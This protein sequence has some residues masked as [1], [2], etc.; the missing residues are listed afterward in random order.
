MKRRKVFF[1]LVLTVIAIIALIGF[2]TTSCGET[3]NEDLLD[4]NYPPGEG[5][6]YYEVGDTRPGGGIIFYYD[7]NGFTMAD[8]GKKAHYLEAAPTDFPDTYE[9]RLPTGS[10]A[11]T[12]TDI[13]TGR[14][15]TAVINADSGNTPAA[16]ACAELNTGGRTDWF[17]P[18]RDELDELYKYWD[19]SGKPANINSTGFYWSSSQSL[20]GYAYNHDFSSDTKRT[21]YMDSNASDVRAI[22]AF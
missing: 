12:G 7:P 21:N 9:W 8:T 10:I 15:N 18:S 20:V 2:G 19:D 4:N 16:K 3:G 17:L 6:G 13:G 22:R 11:G 5:P 1:G 14:K